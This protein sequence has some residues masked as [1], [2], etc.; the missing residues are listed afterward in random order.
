VQL[1]GDDGG[2]RSAIMSM[3]ELQQKARR[4]NRIAESSAREL[5]RET[6]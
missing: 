6:S 1:V 5:F 3:P 4:P 2:V